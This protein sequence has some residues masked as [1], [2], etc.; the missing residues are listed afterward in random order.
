[1]AVNHV[2][3]TQKGE[4]DF[5]QATNSALDFK[6]DACC[7]SSCRNARLCKFYEHS[8]ENYNE[9]DRC[10]TFTNRS[11]NFLGLLPA[12]LQILLTCGDFSREIGGDFLHFSQVRVSL[13]NW[14][15]GVRN[16]KFH[17]PRI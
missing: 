13:P 11:D 3:L 14:W 16:L 8:A 10:G 4:S 5:Q 9:R 2:E 1:M 17:N 7:H 12:A 15:C 6:P